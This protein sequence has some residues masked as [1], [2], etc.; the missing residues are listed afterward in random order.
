MTKP[1]IETQ[2]LTKQYGEIMAVDHLNLN[3]EEGEIFGLLG[4]NGAGKTTLL[5]LLMGL[6]TPT[7]GTATVGGYD[8]VENS[9]DIRKVASLLPEGAGYYGDMTA[10]Q[11]L[12]YIARLNDLDKDEREKRVED[13]LE[14]VGL[15]E[16][17]DVKVETFSRGMKQRLGIAEVLIKDPK[18]LFFDEPTLGLD[19]QAT[20]EIRE[21]IIK[22]SREKGRTVFLSSHLLSEVQQTCSRVGIL[23]HGRLVAIGTM[24]SLASELFKRE[25]INVEFRLTKVTPKLVKDL[26]NIS[27]VT[28]V[29]VEGDRMNIRMV[30]D[31]TMNISETIMS[32]G[33]TILL[34]KP[35]EYTLEEIY[36][37]YYGE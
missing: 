13:L 18:I 26:K 25:G 34:M 37:R 11:N 2:E 32:H 27:G 4:P 36:L 28:S 8:I 14:H 19:P 20:K 16:W 35:R 1:I 5:L 6:T 29:K 33:A 17:A 10:R 30:E 12:D 3:V 23:S 7:S 15:T 9:R 22:L 21:Q 24:E 31:K